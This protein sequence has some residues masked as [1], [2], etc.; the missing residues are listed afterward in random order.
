LF[1]TTF[2]LNLY[3]PDKLQERRRKDAQ[4]N[5][6]QSLDHKRVSPTRLS[7]ASGLQKL[8]LLKR[9]EADSN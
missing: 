7:S 8:N 6:G 5:I 1:A 4:L 9:G 3:L 2:A